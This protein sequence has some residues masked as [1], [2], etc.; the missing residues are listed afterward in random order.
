MKKQTH[1]KSFIRNLFLSVGSIFILLAA[2]FS[3][4][5]YQR[6]KEYKLNIIKLRMQSY[7]HALMHRFGENMGHEPEAFY[8]YIDSCFTGDDIRVTVISPDGKVLL[9]SRQHNVGKL[10]NHLNRK[11]VKDA[12]KSGYGYDIKRTS[13]TMGQEFFYSATY[14][15]DAHAI[16]RIS[17]PYTSHLSSDLEADHT[18]LFFAVL[19][20]FMLGIVLYRNTERIAGHISTLRTFALRAERGEDLRNDLQKKIPND[21][22]GDISRTIMVLYSKLRNSEE[23][24]VRMKRQLTLNATHELKTPAASIQGVLE[25]LH[26]NPNM[27]EERKAFFIERCYA[28][29]VRMSK[30]LQDMAQLTKLD[31]ASRIAEKSRIKLRELVESVVSDTALQLEDSKLK[32]CIDI[33][34]DAAIF[35]EQELTYSIFRN[36]IDNCIAYATGATEIRISCTET[37]SSKKAKPGRGFYEFIVADNGL[38]VDAKH[39]PLLFERFYRVDKGRSRKLGGTGLGLA[40]VKNAVVLHGGTI[41]AEASPG[42]GLTIRFTLKQSGRA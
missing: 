20:T 38:G 8:A 28:Q 13:E 4:F 32:V 9:D 24:K 5:Q 11:E 34:A 12:L 18:F 41:S 15:K 14:F 16:I 27:D 30:L 37:N 42:G 7:S 6:E 33:H 35:G 29:S 17:L 21:E 1:R 2:C 22:L 10:Q 40:I 23:D 39:L 31:E 19:I 25:T 26:S 36:L 3:L